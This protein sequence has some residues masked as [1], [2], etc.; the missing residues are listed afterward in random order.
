MSRK[1]RIL[2]AMIAAAAAPA[3]FGQKTVYI[4]MNGGAF[5]KIYTEHIFPAF[6][7]ANNV[8]VVVVPGKLVN[9]VV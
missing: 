6:E 9:V 3:A 5:E 2:V 1:L 7:K 4:G 8:K